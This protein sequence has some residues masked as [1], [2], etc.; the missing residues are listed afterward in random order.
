MLPE[1]QTLSHGGGEVKRRGKGFRTKMIGECSE[2]GLNVRRNPLF[3]AVSVN[4]Q[5]D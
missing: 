1:R 2:S 4:R 5:R 3:L